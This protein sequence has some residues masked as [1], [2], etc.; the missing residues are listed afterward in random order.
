M[1]ANRGS[2][3]APDRSLREGNCEATAR[4]VLR[5]LEEATLDG[6]ANKVLEPPLQRQV[7]RGR[8]VLGRD[9]GDPGVLAALEPG[10]RITD[11]HDR[12]AVVAERRPDRCRRVLEQP[13]DTD[14]GRRGDPAAGRLVV[15]RDVPP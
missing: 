4:D 9:A 13:D 7:E 2:S 1:E 11:E 10:P 8:A 5:G 6:L 12:V 3:A 15:Q 14:L